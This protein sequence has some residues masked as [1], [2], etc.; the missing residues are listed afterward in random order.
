MVGSVE[1]T[2]WEGL[3]ALVALLYFKTRNVGSETRAT[4]APRPATAAHLDLPG[5]QYAF[6]AAPHLELEN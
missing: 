1:C 6:L 3:L 2:C 5:E 4:K